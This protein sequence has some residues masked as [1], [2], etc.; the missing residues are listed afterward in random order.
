MRLEKR[1]GSKQPSRISPGNK[2]VQAYQEPDDD[3]LQVTFLGVTGHPAKAST[4]T[5]PKLA[6]NSRPE[7]P[8]ARATSYGRDTLKDN[9]KG[10]DGSEG[11]RGRGCTGFTTP[12][13]AFTVCYR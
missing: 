8:A 6:D 10:K 9:Y 1:Q 12:I 7:P 2:R 5:L 11:Q 4:K 13:I 3:I